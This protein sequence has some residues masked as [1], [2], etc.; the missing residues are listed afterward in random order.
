MT[1]ETSNE[2]QAAY[3]PYGFK[4][5]AKNFNDFTLAHSLN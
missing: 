4:L 3:K 5:T 2:I 1:P